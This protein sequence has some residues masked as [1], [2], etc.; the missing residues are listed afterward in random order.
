MWRK[1]QEKP[2]NA[3]L[4]IRL[5]SIGDIVLTSPVLRCIKREYPGAQV[6]FFVKKQFRDVI[7]D[8]PYIDQVHLFEGDLTQNIETFKSIGFSKRWKC[9]Y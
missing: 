9:C 7:T 6:H 2:I 8:N 5:S 3:I 4:V 1:K